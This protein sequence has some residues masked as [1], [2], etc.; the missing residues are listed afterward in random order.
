[1]K[2]NSG[3]YNIKIKIDKISDNY[4]GNCIGIISHNSINNN[5]MGHGT[6]NN[7]DWFNQLYDYIGW[8]T[9]KYDNDK[10]LPNGLYCGGHDSVSVENNIFRLSRF[11]YKSNNKNYTKTLPYL[12]T[13]DIVILS[14]D[15]DLNRLSFSR[16]NDNGELDS[17]ID[18]LPRM[19][20]FYWFVGHTSQP[21]SLTIVD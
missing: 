3:K 18:N 9:L 7:V 4:Y 8:R 5:N 12:K 1:M 11:M 15:S 13:G 14:Y 19:Q 6:R 21:M 2:P 16:E 20:I 17:Y 10:K